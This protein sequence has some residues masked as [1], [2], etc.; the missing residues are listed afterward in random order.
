M[1]KNYYMRYHQFIFSLFS[2]YLFFS[3]LPVAHPWCLKTTF[4]QTDDA[5]D[6]DYNV[7]NN[8]IL[9]TGQNVGKVFVYDAF[10][11]TLL[12]TYSVAGR[13][14]Q[15]SKFTKDGTYIAVGLDNG[16][17]LLINGK[18]PFSATPAYVFV[19]NFTAGINIV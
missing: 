7:N 13:T 19:M 4:N 2:L 12:Y 3:L 17:V 11:Y 16:T 9:S 8:L 14:C 5:T 15:C 6:V 1:V 10:N 18:A